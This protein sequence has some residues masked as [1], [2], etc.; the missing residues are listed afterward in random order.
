MD[1]VMI[2]VIAV[3]VLLGTVLS[4]YMISNTLNNQMSEL[5]AVLVERELRESSTAS[6]QGEPKQKKPVTATEQPKK[7][8][9]SGVN[10]EEL[11]KKLKEAI[12]EKVQNVLE[13]AKRKKE[14]LLMLMDV[15]RGY[16]LG[17]ISE[18]EYNAF[19]MKVLA[20]LDEFKRLWLARFPSQRDKER[21]NQAIAYVS[22]TK[23]PIV[24]K[25]K[26]GKEQMTLPPEEALIKVTSNI[27]S[28]IE[29]L[30]GLIKSRGENPAVTPLEVKL[31]KE[32]ENLKAKVERLERQLEEYSTLT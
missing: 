7:M 5:Y 29:I 22:R 25:S 2:A 18:D 12:D 4:A 20:E 19:L 26:T 31:Y 30:D 13:E 8:N 16:T 15:M 28:A 6:R 21:L 23:L 3:V 1:W 17:Y 10:E 14:R 11:L 9:V 27:N 24:V 32:C